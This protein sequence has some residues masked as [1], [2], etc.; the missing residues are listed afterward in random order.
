MDTSSDSEDEVEV[1]PM[2]RCSGQRSKSLPFNTLRTSTT[3]GPNVASL[4]A[5]GGQP[6]TTLKV[7]T[8]L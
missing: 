2:K 1:I 3:T 5:T 7:K 4:V 6:P 8:F